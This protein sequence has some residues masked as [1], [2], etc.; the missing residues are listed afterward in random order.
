MEL[1]VESKISALLGDERSKEVVA[2]H[3]PGLTDDPRMSMAMNMTLSQI[4]PFSGGK[5]TPQ[6]IEAIAEDLAKL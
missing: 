6:I 3:C 1:T 5:L 2:K 4:I